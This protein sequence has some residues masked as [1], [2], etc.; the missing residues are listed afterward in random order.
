LIDDNEEYESLVVPFDM[1]KHGIKVGMVPPKYGGTGGITVEGELLP[2]CFDNEKL[3]WHIS[4]PT[5]DDM[6]TLRWIELNPPA[7]L[8]EER[9]RRRKKVE[10]PHNIPWEEWRRRLAI[11]PDDVVIALY[12]MLPHSCTWKWKM[13]TVMSQGSTTKADVQDLGIF[14]NMKLWLLIRTSLQK[15]QIKDIHVPK[16]LFDWIRISGSLTQ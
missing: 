11:L 4:K 7:L 2:C 3:Y 12:L 8:G 6:D 10:V 5:Q 9:I 15:S 1:M 14:V 16:C 13:N